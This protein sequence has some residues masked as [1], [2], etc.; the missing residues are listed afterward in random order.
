[1]KISFI[2]PSRNNL[3]YLKWGYNAIQKNKGD[4]EVEICYADDASTDGTFDLA[5]ELNLI[6][7]KHPSNLGYGANQK[8]CYNKALERGADIV[9]M[10]HPDYQYDPKLVP[11]FISYIQD[12]Y[13]DIM[14][15]SRIRS[16]KE[17]L[18]NGMPLY[19]YLGNRF[20]TKLENFFTGLKLSEYHTGYRAYSR[21][22]LE[23]INYEADSDDFIFDQEFLIQAVNKKFRIGEIPV[24]VRYFSEA[25]SINLRR[26]VKYG[27]GILLLMFRF[28]IHKVFRIKDKRFL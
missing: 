19:K 25:S 15:G 12:G 1:M 23:R 6:V 22:V 2:I 26:S 24:P 21:K 16:R 9:V 28:S 20:L 17:V 8:T 7:Y 4:H 14:L 3:K 18:E 5:K 10:L 11:Y 27:L 13:F